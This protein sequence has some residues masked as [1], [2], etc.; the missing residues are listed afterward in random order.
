MSDKTKAELKAENEEL[1]TGMASMM[2]EL[3]KIKTQLAEAKNNPVIIRKTLEP[4]EMDQGEA[5]TAEF[6]TG[7]GED[8]EL[9]IPRAMAPDGPE[10]KQ[11]ADMLDFF[12]MPVTVHIHDTA[13]KNADRIFEIGVNGKKHIF[14]RNREYT[15]PRY[16]VEGLIRAKPISY[17]CEEYTDADGARAYRYPSSSGL[18]YGFSVIKDEHPMGAS[19]LKATLA[20][21]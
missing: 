16:V 14:Q 1:A 15:V 21:P 11:K 18:R 3:E 6:T 8:Q 7:M 13:E 17:T 10:M 4:M 12:R 2:D 5:H 20:Q 9:E 19:W